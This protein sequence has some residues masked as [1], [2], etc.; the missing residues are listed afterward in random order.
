MYPEGQIYRLPGAKQ[1][2]K[3]LKPW[4]GRLQHGRACR[5][6]IARF[7]CHGPTVALRRGWQPISHITISRDVI[8][9]FGGGGIISGFAGWQAQRRVNTLTAVRTNQTRVSAQ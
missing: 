5:A 3:F 9:S 8:R 7:L 1:K 2:R 4:A 6:R